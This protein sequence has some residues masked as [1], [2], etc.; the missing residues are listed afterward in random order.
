MGSSGT[1]LPPQTPGT[2]AHWALCIALIT[3][4]SLFGKRW[5]HPFRSLTQTPAIAASVDLCFSNSREVRNCSVRIRVSEAAIQIIL[6][7][8]QCVQKYKCNE[9]QS[10]LA[11]PTQTKEN[12]PVGLGKLPFRSTTELFH[13]WNSN[14]NNEQKQHES[15]EVS[16]D[17]ISDSRILFYVWY[18]IMASKMSVFQ[19][20]EPEN[21]V[22]HMENET[23][24]M[25]LI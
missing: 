19:F 24:Q 4:S 23:L 9:I 11:L 20:L 18:I 22:P 21:M 13:S 14:K 7:G 1:G 6:V 16:G 10:Y 15:K 25:W 3:A 8:K 2:S 12:Y 5:F 17:L